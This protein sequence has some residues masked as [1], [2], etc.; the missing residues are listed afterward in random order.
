MLPSA[1]F[2]KRDNKRGDESGDDL[3]ARAS[4]GPGLSPQVELS[5]S[6]G[7]CCKKE[8]IPVNVGAF[9]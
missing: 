5:S 4:P 3:M 6:N 9:C 1:A 2:L 8:V 7:L